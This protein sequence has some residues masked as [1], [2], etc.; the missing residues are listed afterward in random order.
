MIYEFKRPSMS[1]PSGTKVKE[2]IVVI[3]TRMIVDL[4]YNP[5]Q[6]SYL[7]FAVGGLNVN[8]PLTKEAYYDIVAIKKKEDEA[9]AELEKTM[10]EFF[11]SRNKLKI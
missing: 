6:G 7:A 8:I 1:F 9:K 3:D 4:V 11:K 5:E 2:A 10:L